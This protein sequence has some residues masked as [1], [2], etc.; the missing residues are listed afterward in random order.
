VRR[1]SDDTNALIEG[2]DRGQD[3]SEVIIKACRGGSSSRVI[4]GSDE[5]LEEQ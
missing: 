4:K 2:I 3:G 5:P 1:T